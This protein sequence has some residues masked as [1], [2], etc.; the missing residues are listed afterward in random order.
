MT[1]VALFTAAGSGM[2][3]EAARHLHE[4]GYE[5]AILSSSGKGEALAQELGGVGY[6]G[7]N[8]EQ[9]DLQA[10]VDKAMDRWG[11]STFWSIPRVTD[12]KATSWKSAMTTGIWEWNTTL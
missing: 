7:S 1:K 5:V 2:G 6:T 8:Q 4:Q 3:A 12:P 11:G 9:M 10:L